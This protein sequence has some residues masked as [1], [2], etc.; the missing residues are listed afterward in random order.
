MEIG[1]PTP[2][3]IGLPR[4]SAYLLWEALP[5]ARLLLQYHGNLVL[6]PG[7]YPGASSIG[8]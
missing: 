6:T 1:F 2:F 4:W 7:L 8:L 5:H 3:L